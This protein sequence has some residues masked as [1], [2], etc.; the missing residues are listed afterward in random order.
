MYKYLFFILFGILTF[1]ACQA[2]NRHH[3]VETDTVVDDYG[4]SVAVPTHP[5]RIVSA[6][7]A[8]TEII[9]ALGAGDLL[10][11]RTD[12]CTYPDEAALIPSIGGISNMNVEHVV[13]LNPDLIISGSM[14]PQNT[15]A[16]LDNLGVPLV[17]VV[18]KKNFQGLYENILQI[19][20]L[21][22]RSEAADSL[23]LEL[24]T[25]AAQYSAE[26]GDNARPTVY[27]VVGF[28]S[29]GNYTA[30][31]HTFI[32]ELITM[33]GGRNI[34]ADVDGWSYSLEALMQQDPDY[35]IIRAEDAKVFCHTAPYNRLSAVRQHRVIAIES[36]WID[37]Q[38][39][40]NLQALQLIQSQLRK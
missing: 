18:E 28:G 40:R 2:P 38:A 26:T 4:R 3:M 21:I 33:A 17:S 9:F 7:P 20:R 15:V 13:S 12:F 32:N 30:G 5:Q 6:S 23:V 36:G 35:I 14:V 37:I 34:A 22:G 27:Y 10:V 8:V 25:C 29:S 11:G 1:V 19:G 24:K 31:G 39:P 16:Q